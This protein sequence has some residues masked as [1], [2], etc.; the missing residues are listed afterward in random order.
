MVWEC[1]KFSALKSGRRTMRF[2]FVSMAVALFA[3]PTHARTSPANPGD[4]AEPGGT[5]ERSV[6]FGIGASDSVFSG[7][8]A[9][10]WF[11]IRAAIV[12]SI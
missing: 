9:F 7:G 2:W 3:L 4:P 5:P 12:V 6:T 11:T 10:G 8:G 1:W